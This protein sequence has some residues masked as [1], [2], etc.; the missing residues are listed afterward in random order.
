MWFSFRLTRFS[1][2]EL[3][4][5]FFV[6][7][8]ALCTLASCGM[9]SPSS[10]RDDRNAPNESFPGPPVSNG[11]TLAFAVSTGQREQ[12]EAGGMQCIGVNEPADPDGTW[13]DN[14][15]CFTKALFN[16][17]KWSERGKIPG[18]NCRQVH[19]AAEPE[20]TSWHDNYLCFSLDNPSGWLAAAKASTRVRFEAAQIMS[21]R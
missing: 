16:R 3:K 2:Q 17:V 9:L 5:F 6:R 15:L 21:R 13:S 7:F 8:F 1:E 19:E 10:L 4:L 14:S 20:H 12:I 18:M 11:L